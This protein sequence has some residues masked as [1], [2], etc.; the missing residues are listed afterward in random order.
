[1]EIQNESEY[2]EK[3]IFY[4]LLGLFLI[5]FHFEHMHFN[6]HHLMHPFMVFMKII[7]GSRRKEA[8]SAVFHMT[9]F[10]GICSLKIFRLLIPDIA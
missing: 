8:T 10:V 6:P 7:K 2:M 1:M 3:F 4:S 5:P 9:V